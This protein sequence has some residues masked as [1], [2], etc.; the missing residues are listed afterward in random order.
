MYLI[1]QN[2]MISKKIRIEINFSFITKIDLN[3]KSFILV[4]KF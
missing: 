2:I 4:K 3:F 1:K